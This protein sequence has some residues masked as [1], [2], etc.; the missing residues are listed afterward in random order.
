MS[1][2]KL[3]TR[4][5]RA[6][7]LTHTLAYALV[8][9][10]AVTGLAGCATERLASAAP[11]GVNLTGEWKLNLNLS[12]D[13]DKLGP[14]P[15]NA[16]QRSPGGHRGHGGGRGGGG[17]PPMGSPN[18]PGGYNYSGGFLPVVLSG[19]IDGPDNGQDAG[20]GN[21]QGGG[22]EPGTGPD[23]GPG[24]GPRHKST[25]SRG[26]SINR[27][28]KAPLH[29]SITQKDG[30][31]LVKTNMPDGTQTTDEYK[32]GATATIPYG[33]DNTADRTTG[34][35]GPVFVVTTDVKKGPWREDDFALDEDGRLIVS[36][37]TKGG[38]LG[39]LDIKRV[40]DRV[41]GAGS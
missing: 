31:I 37:Q 8:C 17:M 21:D 19:G 30:V 27:L 5:A 16:P 18:G 4:L 3:L 24:N 40:Y 15:D 6:H 12:D 11:N 1:T 33:P 36:T 29:M 23:S 13:P 22:S 9:L 26:M 7:V 41:R 39:K 14:D 28:L 25:E 35:R 32:P 34:W 2:P 38:R 10:P 20:P